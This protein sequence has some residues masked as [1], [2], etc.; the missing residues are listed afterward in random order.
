[1]RSVYR[2]GVGDRRSPCAT[3]A[4]GRTGRDCWGRCERVTHRSGRILPYALPLPES[5]TTETATRKHCRGS[6]SGLRFASVSFELRSFYRVRIASA[7]EAVTVDPLA[8]RLGRVPRCCQDGTAAHPSEAVG[9]TTGEGHTSRPRDGVDGQMM[10]R[11]AVAADREAHR[12]CL[13]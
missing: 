10:D 13:N 12:C 9:V 6:G 4:G 5:E 3:I 1:M 7:G 2:V 8:Q 11:G